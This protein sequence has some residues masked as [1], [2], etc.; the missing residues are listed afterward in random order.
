MREITRKYQDPFDL[1]WLNAARQA[2]IMV[3]RSTEVFASWNGKGVLYVGTPS[4]LDADDSLAQLIFH[5]M[6][7][8]LVEGSEAWNRPDWGQTHAGV[9]HEYACLRLQA[10]L[11]G[12]YG[13]RD[14]LA[15]TT[16]FR[17]YFDRLPEDPLSGA[18]KAAV[19]AERGYQRAKERPWSEIL[20][21]A[22]ERSQQIARLIH[23]FAP[24]D[25][26]WAD[27]HA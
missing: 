7:H 24:P 6:C 3:E 17:S 25:S 14:I 20:A 4:T 11:A 13:M 10:T 26:I 12:E 9:I 2:G 19:M 18:G 8:F 27:L 16:E 15:A 22:L 23:P 1:V 21:N 5:E